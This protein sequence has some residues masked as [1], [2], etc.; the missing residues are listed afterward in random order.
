[1]YQLLYVAYETG[2]LQATN[3]KLYTAKRL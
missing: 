3:Y 2:Q 1:M